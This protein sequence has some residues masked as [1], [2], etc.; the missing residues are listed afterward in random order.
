MLALP[1]DRQRSF[2][3][4]FCARGGSDKGHDRGDPT[5]AARAAGYSDKPGLHA[6]ARQLLA[7]ERIQAAI[8]EH[9]RARL[10][11]MLPAAIE[12]LEDIVSTPGRDQLAAVKTILNRAGLPERVTTDV[13]VNVTLTDAEKVASIR[14]NAIKLGLDPEKLLGAVDAEFTE[15]APPA[16]QEVP[17]EDW[18][19]LDELLGL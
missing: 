7:D 15:L 8:V 18:A 16:A 11:G 14:R 5:K 17:E 1:T 10:V 9:S 12:G 6:Q 2:V 19:G 3:V 4:N 13:N